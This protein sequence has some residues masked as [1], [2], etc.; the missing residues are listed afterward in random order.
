ML[1]VLPST[2]RKEASEDADVPGSSY[3]KA[4]EDKAC[5]SRS[6][7]ALCGLCAHLSSAAHPQ[8]FPSR[9]GPFPLAGADTCR[10]LGLPHCRPGACPGQE[11]WR[12]AGKAGEALGSFGVCE[13]PLSHNWNTLFMGHNA[14]ADAIMQKYSATQSKC[15]TMALGS[16]MTVGG[17]RPAPRVIET[18][19]TVAVLWPS[20]RL[21]WSKKCGASSS[22]MASAWTLSARWVPAA[23]LTPP[24]GSRLLLIQ[25]WGQ[26]QGRLGTGTASSWGRWA[27]PGGTGSSLLLLPTPVSTGGPQCQEEPS[28]LRC[29][30]RLLPSGRA[31]GRSIGAVV[32]HCR[33]LVTQLGLGFDP[34]GSHRVPWAFA[35]SRAACWLWSQRVAPLGSS[36]CL[37]TEPP[38]TL[39]AEL[40]ET[41]GRFGSLGCVLLCEGGVTAILEFL[42]P[43]EARKAFRHLA[44]S[45]FHHVP[46]YLEWAPVGIFSSTAPQGKEPKKHLQERTWWSQKPARTG[47]CPG[48]AGEGWAESQELFSRPLLYDFVHPQT[49]GS[50]S[51]IMQVLKHP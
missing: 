48:Q 4:S 9:L 2:I 41:F 6:S 32:S 24:L 34:G 31:P 23:P 19:D 30:F 12:G 11:S 16:A 45:K 49:S 35:L 33:D 17:R 50:R 47:Q 21:S 22:T 38:G 26:P 27:A 5:S 36:M 51:L 3:K 40:Q 44:Y 10:G 8:P 29:Q 28:M 18:K 43:L 39:A 42:E 7:S 15:S 46:L 20:G 25:S 37:A 1:H 14:V 13:R